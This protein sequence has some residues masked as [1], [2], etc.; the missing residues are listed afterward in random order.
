PG[1]SKTATA[2]LSW[3]EVEGEGKAKPLPT[4]PKRSCKIPMDALS[5]S[6]GVKVHFDAAGGHTPASV[7]IRPSIVALPRPLFKYAYQI[8]DDVR[9]NGDGLVQRGE[10]VTIHLQVKN[11]GTGRSYET[12]AN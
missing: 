5:R 4:N 3:C 6:D 7:E 10:Q 2:P 9:G 12:Q 8:A 1:E 11:V